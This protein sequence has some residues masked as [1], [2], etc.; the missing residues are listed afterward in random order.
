MTKTTDEQLMELT[1]SVQI[2][3]SGIKLKEDA[4]IEVSVLIKES[5]Y[6]IIEEHANSNNMIKT[7]DEYLKELAQEIQIFISGIKL[8][9]ESTNEVC[10][11]IEQSEYNMS[12]GHADSNNMIRPTEEQLMGLTEA[13]QILIGESK[14]KRRDSN[15]GLCTR[16]K[17][18]V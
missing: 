16:L 13:I 2:L 11:L 10:V 7:T 9:E 4:S 5:E 12:E 14:L 6:N 1:Q 15:W 18:E 17:S 8:K 3:I